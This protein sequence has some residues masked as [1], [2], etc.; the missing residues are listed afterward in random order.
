MFGSSTYPR[1]KDKFYMNV[2]YIYIQKAVLI[3]T[4]NVKISQGNFKNQIIK[5][6]RLFVCADKKIY[7]YWV[8]F[9]F[10][11]MNACKDRNLNFYD[12]I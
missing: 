9:D 4:A 10:T 5:V 12:I 8:T 2:F 7:V 6:L 11:V 1:I 3:A